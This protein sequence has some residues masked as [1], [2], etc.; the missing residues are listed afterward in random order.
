MSFEANIS[1]A[2]AA[3]GLTARAGARMC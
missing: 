2:L 1:P 3:A